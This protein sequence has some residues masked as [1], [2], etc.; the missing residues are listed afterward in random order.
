MDLIWTEAYVAVLCRV[1]VETS[2]RI[3][4]SR[5]W[6]LEVHV[7]RA[8]FLARETYPHLEYL[9]MGWVLWVTPEMRNWTSCQYHCWNSLCCILH[10]LS[11]SQFTPYCTWVIFLLLHL[12]HFIWMA[13]E[14]MSR[15]KAGK[16]FSSFCPPLPSPLWMSQDWKF[17]SLQ[18]QI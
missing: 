3:V 5:S 10:F 4:K 16:R 8:E 2:D 13:Q 18:N 11:C 6:E 7:G 1:C 9:K 14:P 15:R 12:S 17:S